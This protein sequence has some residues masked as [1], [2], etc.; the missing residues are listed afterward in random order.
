MLPRRNPEQVHEG[1]AV[2]PPL[3]EDLPDWNRGV[4]LQVIAGAG[5]YTVLTVIA[6][7]STSALRRIRLAAGLCAHRAAEVYPAA[8]E[9][10]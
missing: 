7:E 6:M 10:S 3:G 8:S 5:R 4:S 2:P 1:G 9:V